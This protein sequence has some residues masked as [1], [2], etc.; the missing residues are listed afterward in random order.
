ML[1][2]P[3]SRKTTLK[4]KTS[5]EKS[6]TH[7]KKKELRI[8]R[9]NF[10]KLHNFHL[11]LKSN[12]KRQINNPDINIQL[13]KIINLNMKMK[14]NIDNFSYHQIISPVK[15][16]KIRDPEI[17]NLKRENSFLTNFVKKIIQKKFKDFSLIEKKLFHEISD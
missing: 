17:D 16:V 9:E 7:Q 8:L 2:S 13:N 4:K 10:M 14:A 15:K 1:T 5:I 12:I 6:F 11:L 3:N